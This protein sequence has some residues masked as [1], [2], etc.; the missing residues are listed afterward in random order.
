MKLFALI[1]A[2]LVSVAVADPGVGCKQTGGS[3]RTHRIYRQRTI[4]LTQYS[5]PAAKIVAS[6]CS[7][8]ML[9]FVSRY[10]QISANTGLL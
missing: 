10:C 3:V 1:T 6:A 9:A 5:V 8:P 7:V 2:L 4:E